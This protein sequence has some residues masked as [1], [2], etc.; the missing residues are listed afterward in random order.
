MRSNRSLRFPFAL[1]ASVALS[2]AA[3]AQTPTVRFVATNSAF[4]GTDCG[5]RERPCRTISQAVRNASDGDLI[6]VGPG[7]YP[8]TITIDKSVEI[9]STA[10][11]ALT[12]VRGRDA[13]ANRIVII[14]ASG[15]TFGRL[16]GGFTITGTKLDLGGGSGTEG[17]DG[18]GVDQSDVTI[19]GNIV[20]GHTIGMSA[21]ANGGRIEG[22]AAIDNEAGLQITGPG[23]IVI[24]NVANGNKQGFLLS[25]V[26]TRTTF[27]NNV[28]IG[29]EVGIEIGTEIVS[30]L[31][32]NTIIG[33]TQAGFKFMMPAQTTER[34]AM[35]RNNIYGNGDDADGCGVINDTGGVIDATNNYWGKAN[36]P[37]PNPGDRAYGTCLVRGS[38]VTTPF[39]TDPFPIGTANAQ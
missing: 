38:I 24:N 16:N 10:G 13:F 20:V 12:V 37:G 15:V 7:T 6:E 36:G 22:N 21:G 35:H 30:E 17:I 25:L 23:S 32:G 14:R 18:G 11:A 27:T 26:G 5:S 1:F 3:H 33:N 19:A 39:A 34:F 4:N 9:Y 31:S 8:G 2:Q 28:A 29:N